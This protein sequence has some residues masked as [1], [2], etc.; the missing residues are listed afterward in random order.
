M[1]KSEVFLKLKKDLQASAIVLINSLH[2]RLNAHGRLL[3]PSYD[4]ALSYWR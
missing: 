2:H 4:C 3:Y 1:I